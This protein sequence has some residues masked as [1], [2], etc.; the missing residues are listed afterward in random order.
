MKRK[1]KKQ[2]KRTER[3]TSGWSIILDIIVEILDAI[4]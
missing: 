1:D 4:F 3:G 2:K